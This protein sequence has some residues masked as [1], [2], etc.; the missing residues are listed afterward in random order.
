[1]KEG[2][3]IKPPQTPIKDVLEPEVQ[4]FI[5]ESFPKTNDDNLQEDY[6]YKFV[7]DSNYIDKLNENENVVKD[8]ERD[9]VSALE[10]AQNDKIIFGAQ[11]EIHR[12]LNERVAQ[13]LDKLKNMELK[14]NHHKGLNHSII[15]VNNPPIAHL[16]ERQIESIKKELNTIKNEKVGPQSVGEVL[17]LYNE[18]VQ[19]YNTISNVMNNST[20]KLN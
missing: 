14:P 13:L 16:F 2:F 17:E 4:A 19:R 18:A 8:L 11:L 10:K 7:T 15:E 6:A 5:E 20:S 1:M 3:H 12:D 9:A